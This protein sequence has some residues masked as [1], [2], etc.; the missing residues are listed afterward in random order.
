MQRGLDL[1]CTFM[2]KI[3]NVHFCTRYDT[4]CSTSALS[5]MYI[6]VQDKRSFNNLKSITVRLDLCM[7]S[8]RISS[9]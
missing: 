2:Y 6:F 4:E 1:L 3:C 7:T 8:Y 9:W 5:V